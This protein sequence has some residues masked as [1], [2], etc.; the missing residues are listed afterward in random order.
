MNTSMKIF[1]CIRPS[2][3]DWD[4]AYEIESQCIE[5][6]AVKFAEQYD[7][8]G[9]DYIYMRQGGEVWAREQGHN[10]HVEFIIQGEAVPQYLAFI[11]DTPT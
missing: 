6:A 2:S 3:M 9:A 10:D 8:E 4:D 5:N 7:C 11:K 1:E